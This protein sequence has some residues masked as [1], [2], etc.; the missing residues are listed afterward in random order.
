MQR[1]FGKLM[2]KNPGDNAKVSAVL[3]DYEDADTVL[4]RVCSSLATTGPDPTPREIILTAWFQIIE[5][6]RSWRDSWVALTSTQLGVV[7]E[8]ESL[9]D[10]IEGTG[11]TNARDAVAT[12][13]LQLHRTF[14][15]KEAYAELK[16]ELTEELGQIETNVIAPAT[17]ARDCLAPIK[18]TI[19]KRDNRRLDYEKAQDKALKLQRKPGK[20]SKDEAA[21]AKAQEELAR[22]TDVRIP[23][24]CHL[25]FAFWIINN[26]TG[27][28]GRRQ[29]CSGDAAAH[30]ERSL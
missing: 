17:S 20:S 23:S 1:Q 8:Y 21:L 16:T 18:K 11:R 28:S 12:P 13:E 9:Y 14:G 19:K 2:N 29:P 10:P 3:N 6:A 26:F 4:Q 7:T 30:R 15:L 5:N 22:A 27:V 25:G 24:V